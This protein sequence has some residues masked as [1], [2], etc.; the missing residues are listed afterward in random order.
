MAGEWPLDAEREFW[1]DV[2]TPGRHEHSLWWFVSIAAGWRF[3]CAERGQLRW[4]QQRV[5][6]PWLDWVQAKVEEWWAHRDNPDLLP[7]R[8]QMI[9]CVPR[10]FGKSNTITKSL[11]L[12]AHLRE[13]NLTCYIGSEVHSK[14]KAFLDPMQQIMAGNDPYSWFAWLFGEYYHP[15]RTWNKEE[16]VTA[17]R[18]S[19]G[20]TE[21]T[22]GTFGVETGL[23]SKHPLLC[24]YDD[25]VSAD[26]LT[27]GGVWLRK[28]LQSLDSIY[29][30]L[31]GDSLF[32][33]IGTRYEDADPIGT[34]LLTEGVR[35]W[36]G[37]PPIDRI[38]PGKWDVYFLQARDRTDTRNYPQG[39]PILPEGGATHQALLD[40]AGRNS[41]EHASQMMNDPSHGEHI[42]LTN[43][44][45][46]AMRLNRPTW[47]EPQIPFEY[48]TIHLDTAFKDDTTRAEGCY[49]V[50]AV[51][52]HDLRPNGI[53]Y[54]DQIWA[55]QLAR[56]EQFD[57]KLLGIL[58]NLR[59]RGIRIRAITDEP[60]QG[61]K[62]GTY[63]QH[64]EQIISGAGLSIPEIL[65]LSRGGTKKDVRIREAAAYWL[66]NCVRIFN[67][68]RWVDGIDGLKW[69]MT[70]IGR[71][72]Y[73]DI[74]DACADVFRPEIYRGRHNLS[75]D[76][77]PPIPMQPGDDVLKDQIGRQLFPERY[78]SYEDLYGDQPESG[79][80]GFNDSSSRGPW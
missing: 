50:I 14:A 5:H 56:G 37:H 12:W 41:E 51:W 25:P 4:L 72:R 55:D 27:E 38:K 35:D 6:Q 11:P 62:R 29:P 17:A 43:E 19:M 20:I 52:L 30:A 47:D 76:V 31:R 33:L 39:E 45:I 80:H 32:I 71:C 28:V 36:A 10:Y 3:R 58:A 15:D 40:Y 24:I 21:P 48:A 9:I 57:A 61:G 1:S 53:V 78:Q 46:D 63:K 60:E 59:S 18:V 65:L 13:P 73:K 8:R 26:K 7:E 68:C 79:A 69:Q 34:S 2:C 23:T 70:R 75:G 16:C 77:Q 42:E 49:N 66:D 74:S 44:Q 54:L 64:L 67:D 22:F